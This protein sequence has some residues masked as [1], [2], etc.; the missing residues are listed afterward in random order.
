MVCHILSPVEK[1][2]YA[3]VDLCKLTF[4]VEWK[5]GI[6]RQ[7]YS[8]SRVVMASEKTI[9]VLGASGTVGSGVVSYY[10]REGKTLVI[11][12]IKRISDTLSKAIDGLSTNLL[13]KPEVIYIYMP[14]L[15][16][17]LRLLTSSIKYRSLTM[18]V[19]D[20]LSWLYGSN[21]MSPMGK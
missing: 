7:Y 9:L 6:L 17:G 19:T 14:R 3:K 4:E 21:H 12:P 11:A 13:L 1:L 16:P 5:K 20:L 2:T 10:L 18:K 15:L 8:L